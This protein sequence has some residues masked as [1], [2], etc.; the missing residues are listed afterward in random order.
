MK[1]PSKLFLLIFLFCCQKDAAARI[2]IRYTSYE[3]LKPAA[4]LPNTTTYLITKEP[5]WKEDHYLDLATL[6]VEYGFNKIIP[7]W[8][9]EPPRLVGYDKLTERYY[10]LGP[11]ELH[12]ILKENNL[13]EKK[14]LRINFYK[15]HGG[16]VFAGILVLLIIYG[17]M[18]TRTRKK[19]ITPQKI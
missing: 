3:E 12:I 11:E 10:E 2:H 5:G 15:R 19:I 8:V 16:K 1:I 6:T 9:K 17:L 7:I 18:P 13:D 14:M 4:D